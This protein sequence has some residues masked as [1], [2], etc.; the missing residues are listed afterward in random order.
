MCS[1][2]LIDME[3][4]EIFSMNFIKAYLNKRCQESGI[5]ILD[6]FKMSGVHKK[7]ARRWFDD[8]HKPSLET[9]MKLEEALNCY[10]KTQ[11]R[12]G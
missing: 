10:D 6:L 3:S 1:E 12:Q 8:K 7:T 4:K 5:T 2:R 9:L 11:I